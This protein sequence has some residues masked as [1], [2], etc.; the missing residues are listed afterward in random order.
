[1]RDAESILDQVLASGDDL[2]TEA[3]VGDLLGLVDAETVTA[4]L[5]ALVRGKALAGLAAIDG[6]E[7]RGRDLHVFLDQVVDAVRQALTGQL[8]GVSG[9]AG[10]VAPDGSQSWPLGKIVAVARR[11]AAIDPSRASIGG[12]RF[13]LELALLDGAASERVSGAPV[14]G[15][16]N[17]SLDPAPARAKTGA[18]P[19]AAAAPPPK[20]VPREAVPA[21]RPRTA[22][23][24][25]PVAGVAAADAG[26][27]AL[28]VVAAE[29]V[30]AV[31]AVGPG[32]GRQASGRT[33]PSR[34]PAWPS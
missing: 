15:T 8:G 30:E 17:Q 16:A 7:E 28:S 11:L 3:R 31:D 13:Q 33:R 32:R 26:A 18:T 6:L 22:G 29:S 24:A 25:K 5:D 27:A 20:A 12:L 14:V 4:F 10:A 9:S 23:P 34:A 2:L 1:M 19:L 21:A